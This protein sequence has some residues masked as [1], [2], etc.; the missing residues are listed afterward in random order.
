MT[1]NSIDSNMTTNFIAR[2]QAPA[3]RKR[4]KGS[5]LVLYL[6]LFVFAAAILATGAVF[7]YGRMMDG[8]V[9]E[10][11]KQ[12]AQ[13]EAGVDVSALDLMEQTASKLTL[14]RTV[15]EDHQVIAPLFRFLENNTLEQVRYSN[16]S[17]VGEGALSMQGEATSY[18]A[19][20]QQSDIFSGSAVIES[21]IFSGFALGADGTVR[22][23][24][25]VTPV[26]GMTMY[27]VQ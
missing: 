20:A 24:L 19:I 5:P 3:G 14:A 17:Y 25:R 11:E 13:A 8:Q 12:L 16:F 15:F 26:E 21:H 27:L 6:G 7:L 9:V 2:D 4:K 22:F 10:L 18:E 1:P 23:D